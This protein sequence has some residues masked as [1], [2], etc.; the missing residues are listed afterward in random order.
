MG[1]SN[2]NDMGVQARFVACLKAL[3]CAPD[4]LQ[5]AAPAAGVDGGKVKAH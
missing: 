4:E 1:E 2:V 5:L 3:G